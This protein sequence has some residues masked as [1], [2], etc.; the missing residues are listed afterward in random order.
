[1]CFYVLLHCKHTISSMTW[2]PKRC[3]ECGVWGG[4]SLTFWCYAIKVTLSD[5]GV[6]TTFQRGV[7][8][9]ESNDIL[10][11]LMKRQNN[12]NLSCMLFKL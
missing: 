12:K 10:S 4:Q 11:F 9:L 2:C 7:Y 1:M 8:I 5:W 6:Q 3:A